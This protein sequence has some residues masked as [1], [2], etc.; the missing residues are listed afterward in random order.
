MIV[1]T[2]SDQLV[3]V[4][5]QDGVGLVPT[6]TVWGVAA[7]LASNSAITKLYQIKQREAGKPTALLISDLSM[8][9]EYGQLSPMAMGLAKSHWPGAL[10]L[11]VER[12]TGQVSDSVTGGTSKVGLRMPDYPELTQL[13]TQLG[14]PLVTSSANKAGEPPAT[15]KHLI[16]PDII[17]QVDFL[18]DGECSDSPPSTVVDV[19]GPVLRILRQGAI[20]LQ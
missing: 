12:Q 4:L 7:S 2:D 17:K 20:Q 13:I 5:R 15:K 1:T 8:A 6:D 18:Y 19:S 10:T 11:V 9:L 14:Q 16:D 3:E